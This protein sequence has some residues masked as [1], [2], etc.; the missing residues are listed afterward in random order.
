MKQCCRCQGN[1]VTASAR[2]QGQKTRQGQ[3]CSLNVLT[4]A[5]QCTFLTHTWALP[6]YMENCWGAHAT[7]M[8]TLRTPGVSCQPRAL[9]CVSGS[10][11]FAL[12]P[13]HPTRSQYL[14]TQILRADIHSKKH[15]LPQCEA[16]RF[17]VHLPSR[18][19]FRILPLMLFTS[20][21]NH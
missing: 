11:V 4:S 18:A 12:C 10:A 5:S 7:H 15:S 1:T 2:L 9:L 14:L 16:S 21:M 17:R 20:V 13:Q 3:H 6:D 19:I 8:V